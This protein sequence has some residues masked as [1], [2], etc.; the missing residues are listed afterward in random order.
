MKYYQATVTTTGEFADTVSVILID[1]GSEGVTVTDYE[2][3]K[4]VLS[5]HTWDYVDDALLQTV[6]TAVYVSGYYPEDYDFSA[7]NEKLNQLRSAAYVNVGSLELSLNKI[8]SADYENEWKKYYIPIEL[9]KIVIVPKWHK[10]S[11]NKMPVYIDPGMAFGTGNHETTKLCLK[12]LETVD[13]KGEKCADIGCGSGILGAAAI[14]LGADYCFM[15]DIDEQAVEASNANCA[16]NNAESKVDICKGTLCAD[17]H[18]NE[19]YCVVAN[20]TADVLINLRDAFFHV[21]R[22]DGLLITSGIIHS[23]VQEVAKAFSEKFELQD[24]KCDGEWQGMLW[25]K[26]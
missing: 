14:K 3:V 25:K 23:R 11:G 17:S 1:Y 6:D 22:D 8:D 21:L 15:C 4:R 18:S 10:Y 26:K 24:S 20:I 9:N 7:L 19:F 12:Y 13:L 5:E 16:L 2:D